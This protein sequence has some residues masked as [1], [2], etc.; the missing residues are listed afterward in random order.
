[1]LT[2]KIKRIYEPPVASDG[3]RI[4]VDRLWPRG[5]TKETADIDLWLKGIAPSTELREWFGHD[6]AKWP[7]FRKEY[8]S[9]L[10]EN[11][12]LKELTDCIKK[13]KPVTLL[14]AAKDE[15]HNQAVVL[16]Q[17]IHSLIK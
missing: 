9:E 17:Y 16:Q 13:H 14:Y 5:V 4:L 2:I 11:P 7:A 15:S 6:P 8:I 12:A 1:M 3:Y 10:K